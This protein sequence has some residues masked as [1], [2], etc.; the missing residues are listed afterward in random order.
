[1]IHAVLSNSLNPPYPSSFPPPPPRER[2][3]NREGWLSRGIT[4]RKGERGMTGFIISRELIASA[5]PSPPPV[6]YPLRSFRMQLAPKRLFSED[7]ART[8]HDELSPPPP[9]PLEP[10]CHD[11]IFPT[12]DTIRPPPPFPP[13]LSIDHPPGN[14]RINRRATDEGKERRI[15]DDFDRAAFEDTRDSVSKKL[16]LLRERDERFSVIKLK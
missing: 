6:I 1:M 15:G 14:S 13:Q 4:R 9:S 11:V 10:P 5:P 7:A 16:K 2:D 3:N 8:R 12:V